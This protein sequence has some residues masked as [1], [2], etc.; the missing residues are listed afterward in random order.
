MAEKPRCIGHCLDAVKH[1]PNG[2]EAY[3][4]FRWEA[5]FCILM[6][7]VFLFAFYPMLAV[8]KTPAK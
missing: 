1:F 5:Y 7:R 6:C 3:W 8:A 2:V 4:W